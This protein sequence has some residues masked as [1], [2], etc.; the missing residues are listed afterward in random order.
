MGGNSFPVL[1]GNKSFQ[2]P[3]VSPKISASGGRDKFNSLENKVWELRTAD[4][5]L[6]CMGHVGCG[7]QNLSHLLLSSGNESIEVYCPQEMSPLR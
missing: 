3:L 7:A 5:K 2:K 1:Y 4:S 6:Y